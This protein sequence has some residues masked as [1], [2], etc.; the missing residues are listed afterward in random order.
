MNG[1]VTKISLVK[2]QGFV[3]KKGLFLFTTTKKKLNKVIRL[4]LIWNI[5]VGGVE[6]GYS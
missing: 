3:E 2:K 5:V 1:E 4:L 6:H